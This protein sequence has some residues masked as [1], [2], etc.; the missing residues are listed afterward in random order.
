MRF[1]IAFLVFIIASVARGSTDQSGDLAASLDQ[2]KSQLRSLGDAIAT[3][4]SKPSDP[5]ST[6]PSL[7]EK[8]PVPPANVVIQLLAGVPKS[9]YSDLMD[10]IARQELM[11]SFI[12]EDYPQWYHDLPAGAKNYFSELAASMTEAGI[13]DPTS[14]AAAD[15]AEATHHGRDEL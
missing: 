14:L 6:G 10:P 13:Y 9:V 1:S 7:L 12:D 4:Q 3:A 2:L 11:K 8:L 5:E 15:S